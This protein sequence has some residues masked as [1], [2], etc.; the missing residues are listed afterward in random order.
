M[1]V[2]QE[3]V[4]DG[5]NFKEENVEDNPRKIRVSV[6]KLSVVSSILSN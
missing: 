4:F 1:C 5:V 3:D 6:C 2:F